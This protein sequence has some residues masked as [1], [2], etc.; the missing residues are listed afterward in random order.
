DE[1]RAVLHDPARG[2]DEVVF[3]AELPRLSVVERDRVDALEQLHEIRTAALDPEVH[4]V[5]RDELGPLDLFQDLELQSRIDVPKEDEGR[6]AKL[7]GDLGLE[8]REDAQ[9]RLERLRDI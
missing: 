9:M 4:R 8:V 1:L 6:L 7:R 2:L 3:L 5:A